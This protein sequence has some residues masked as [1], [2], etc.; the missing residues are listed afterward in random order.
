MAPTCA[1]ITSRGR[2]TAWASG[3]QPIQM[4]AAADPTGAVEQ[5]QNLRGV[6]DYS[7]L[8]RACLVNLD[9]W[10]TEGME[11]PPSRTPAASPT[12]PRCRPTIARRPSTRIPDAGYPRHHRAR[13]LGASTSVHAP[14]PAGAC[15][16]LARLRGGR[17]RQRGRRHRPAR[18]RG[19]D[20]HPY[21]LEPTPS[22]H[23]RRRAAPGLRRRHPALPADAGASARRRATRALGRGALRLARGLSRAGAAAAIGSWPRGYLLEDDVETSL[24]FAARLWDYAA[25]SP[26][27]RRR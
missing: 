8:L 2:S 11:P 1:S 20:R 26:S 23:R 12:A 24:R 27:P 13:P 3:R 4:A 19:T 25:A 18:G 14:A 5:S 7:A 22:R 16:R 15:L 9:R 17:R 10:V 6:V 21:G